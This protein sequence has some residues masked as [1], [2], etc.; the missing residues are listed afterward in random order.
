MAAFSFLWEN[1]SFSVGWVE[2]ILVNKSRFV[3]IMARNVSSCLFLCFLV[4]TQW[5]QWIGSTAIEQRVM[6]EVKTRVLETITGLRNDIEPLESTTQYHLQ[7]TH[8]PIEKLSQDFYWI[9]VHSVFYKHECSW[10][11]W[12]LSFSLLLHLSHFQAK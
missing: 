2:V 7:Q 10:C 8:F 1:F 6:L 4:T 3:F 5:W 11:W 9:V 12:T